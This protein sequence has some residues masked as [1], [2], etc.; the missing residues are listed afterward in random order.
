MSLVHYLTAEKCT[1]YMES[2][3][4]LTAA[5]LNLRSSRGPRLLARHHHIKD[6]TLVTIR[7]VSMSKVTTTSLQPIKPK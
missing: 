5:I 2:S 6:I 3:N 7:L 1:P 4:H